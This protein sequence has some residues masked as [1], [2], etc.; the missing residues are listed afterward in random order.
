MSN[1]NSSMRDKCRALYGEARGDDCYARL[2]ALLD[3]FRAES[4]PPQPVDPAGRVSERDVMLITYGGSLNAAGEPPLQTLHRF[5]CEHLQGAISAVHILP[6]FPYSS[7]DGFSVIDYAAVDPALGTW[8]DVRRLGEDFDLMFDLVINHV[9]AQSEWFQRFKAGD[10]E[11]EEFFIRVSPDT[12]LSAVVRPRTLPL[13][14]PVET[15]RGVEHVWTTFSSDQIDLNFANPDVLL[16]M[17][18]VLLFYVRQRMTFVR[19]DAIAYLWKRIGT[20]CIH[21][22]ETHT[23][24]RLFRDIFDAVAPQ[25]AIITE[26]NVPHEENVSYFGNGWDEAQ[27]V[28]QFPLPPLTLHAIAT[29]DATALS[30]WAAGLKRPSPATTFFNFTASH[31]GIGV[32]PLEGILPR[33][34][35][36]RLV[37]RVQ[38]HGG[39]VSYKTNQDG[40]QSPYELNINYF[41]ALSDP[42]GS[43]P[44]ERQVS[45]FLVSQ[46]ILLALAGV[47]GI[48]IHSLLG[49]RNWH[50]GVAQTGRPRSINREPLA[51]E[52]VERALADPD[53]LRAQVFYGYRRLIETRGSEPAF[54]PGG[55]QQVLDLHPALFALLRTSP[56]GQSRVAALHNVSGETIRTSLRALD[57]AGSW[58]DLLSGEQF[59]AAAAI[60]LAPYQ[61]RWL[62]NS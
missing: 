37:E 16:R 7:D 53:A 2:V 54:H 24:V 28:Y 62:K 44:V 29:G 51:V 4:G 48:Y 22:D 49:S 58:R 15:A 40:T 6:F 57:G 43:E 61:V 35:I 27:L 47:P 21:L 30:R 18:E 55:A 20:S 56:D 41:D 10:S 34:E 33:A 50:E 17:V 60:T 38:R 1:L 9:S 11:Y 13:L 39:A 46:A 23:V 42:H 12:D 26:T 14:T 31:D 36:D 19:L 8:D 25:V 5:L 32:R 52:E 3:A 45:R 59:G